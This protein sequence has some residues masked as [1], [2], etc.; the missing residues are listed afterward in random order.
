MNP[1]YIIIDTNNWIYLANSNDPLDGGNEGNHFKLFEKLSEKIKEGSVVLLINGLIKTEWE[2]NKLDAN[3][4]IEKYKKRTESITTTLKN[5]QK[6]LGS[7]LNA[8]ITSV[9][10]GYR[11]LME[12]KISQN[13]SH[14]NNVVQLLNSCVEIDVSNEIKV[15]VSDWAVAKQ[16]PFIGDKKNSTADALILFSAVEYIKSIS[17]ELDVF[18]TPFYNSPRSI[19][20][21]GN[22]GDFSATNNS[23]LIHDHLKPILDEVNMLFFRSLPRAL[24]HIDNLLFQETE[25]AK[26]ELEIENLDDSTYSCDICSGDEDN[27]Y[28]NLVHFGKVEEIVNETEH[29]SNPNQLT[30]EL[31]EEFSQKMVEE[32]LT[33]IVIGNCNYCDSEYIECQNCGQ[34]FATSQFE[35]PERIDCPGCNVRYRKIDLST[36]NGGFEVEYRVVEKTEINEDIDGEE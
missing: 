4:L 10:S 3:D 22:K 13:E 9:I 5:V 16:A 33:S 7:T 12:T 23:D 24:D 20:V 30:I 15:K 36:P 6:E 31:G 1:T 32:R 26:M 34:I 27:P 8:E 35:N 21:S 28:S 25:I 18:D 11:S 17:D 14:V 2:R 19:F 29:S